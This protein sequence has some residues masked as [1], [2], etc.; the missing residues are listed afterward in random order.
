MQRGIAAY[1]FQV[2][3]FTLKEAIMEQ[4]AITAIEGRRLDLDMDLLK[5][6][7]G[8]ELDGDEL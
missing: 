6:T 3:K 1:L 5:R 2:G 8:K 4:A 7:I